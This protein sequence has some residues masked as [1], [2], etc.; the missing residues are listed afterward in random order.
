MSDFLEMHALADG[1]LEGEA[2]ALAESRLQD[3]AFRAEFEA[4]RQ[5]RSVL[6]SRVAP[7]PAP[8]VWAACVSRLDEI[9]KRKRVEGF[10]GKYAWG[11]CSIIFALIISAGLMN[12]YNGRD[13]ATGDVARLAAG[14]AP[15]SRSVTSQPTD[16]RSWIQDVSHGAPLQLDSGSLRIVS[17]AQSIEGDR[18]ITV[19]YCADGAGPVNLV[20]VKGANRITGAEPMLGH[21]P[22][23][24]GQIQDSNSLSWT[25]AGFAFTLIGRRPHEELNRIADGIRV[26]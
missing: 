24:A 18:Y 14:L 9:D 23:F 21:S 6:Q 10:V 13:V 7:D 11:M 2:K 26:R 25:D 20:I 1:Q 5:L 17:Y 4:V 22:Y 19:L 16:M 15:F 3:P 8:P 12:R